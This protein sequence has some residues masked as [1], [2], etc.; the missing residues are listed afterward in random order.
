MFNHGF[1]LKIRVEKVKVGLGFWIIN[2][3]IDISGVREN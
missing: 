1:G 3:L 2:L